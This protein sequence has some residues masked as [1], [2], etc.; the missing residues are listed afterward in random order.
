MATPPPVSPTLATPPHVSPTLA[1]PPPVPPTL[2]TS[3]SVPMRKRS[4]EI[5]ANDR[6]SRS[7]QFSI[8][9]PQCVLRDRRRP[10]TLLGVLHGA[11]VPTRLLSCYQIMALACSASMHSKAGL[12]EIITNSYRN[13]EA[14]NYQ[15]SHLREP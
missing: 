14:V 3:P 6:L 5:I 11:S 13:T 8:D 12:R 2:A 7:S 4:R 9:I 15:L 1:T 10:S